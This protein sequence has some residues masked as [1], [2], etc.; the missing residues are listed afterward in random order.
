[1]SGL[2]APAL[3]AESGASV[4]AVA[5]PLLAPSFYTVRA[6]FLAAYSSESLSLFGVPHALSYAMFSGSKVARS[7]MSFESLIACIWLASR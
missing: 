1:M 7:A 5:I 3:A 2:I 4:E 6:L